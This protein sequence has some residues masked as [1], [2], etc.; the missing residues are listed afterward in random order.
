MRRVLKVF[1]KV[2]LIILWIIVLII[3]GLIINNKVYY[4]NCK[5]EDI[6]AEVLTNSEMMDVASV[7]EYLTNHGDDIYDGFDAEIE[8][9]IYNKKYEFLFSNNKYDGVWIFTEYNQLTWKNIYRREANNPQ[10]FATKIEDN[11]A[12]SFS[13]HNYFNVSLLEQIPIFIPP[14]LFS[15]DDIAYRGVVIHEMAHAM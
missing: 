15:M 11:W 5:T 4:K 9:I 6:D 12:G 3:C 2:I 14:Q 13:T 1:S 8:L 7:Y 10:A